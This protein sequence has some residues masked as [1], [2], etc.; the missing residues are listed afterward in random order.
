MKIIYREHFL[1]FSDVD[2]D[3]SSFGGLPKISL[4]AE[5]PS[6]GDTTLRYPC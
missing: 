5:A 3:V 2:A 4:L 1:D 6:A